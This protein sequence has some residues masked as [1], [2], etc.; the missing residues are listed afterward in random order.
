[1]FRPSNTT[2]DEEVFTTTEDISQSVD[3]ILR[4]VES[5]R[6]VEDQKVDNEINKTE[7]EDQLK[8]QKLDF[9]RELATDKESAIQQ[10][11]RESEFPGV[12]LDKS[13]FDELKSIVTREP[14]ASRE[15]RLQQYQQ[16]I[17]DDVEAALHIRELEHSKQ[18]ALSAAKSDSFVTEKGMLQNTIDSLKA[19]IESQKDLTRQLAM[20]MTS[21]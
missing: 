8:K 3:E 12:V 2:I 10:F 11:Q 14:L 9:E 20:Q 6:S 18:K 7:G 4:A 17:L 15:S 21:S 1:M 13:D 16:E 5:M 19:E